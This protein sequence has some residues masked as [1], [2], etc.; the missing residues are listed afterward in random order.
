VNSPVPTVLPSGEPGE[1]A[2]TAPVAAPKTC[3]FSFNKD[4]CASLMANVPPNEMYDE[5]LSPMTKQRA[6]LSNCASAGVAHTFQDLTRSLEH[7]SSFR[8]D[9]YTFCGSSFISCK[10]FD[11]ATAPAI[12]Q[13]CGDFQQVTGG[14]TASDN[15]GGGGSTSGSPI[16]TSAFKAMVIIAAGGLL[17]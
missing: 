6:D 14:C 13:Q 5:P 11:D 8:C 4:R 15:G 3:S 16:H 7:H 12:P 17:L 2:T 1:P 9:C 10:D